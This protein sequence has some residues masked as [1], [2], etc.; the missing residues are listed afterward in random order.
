MSIKDDLSWNRLQGRRALGSE[1]FAEFNKRMLSAKDIADVLT[2]NNGFDDL[3]DKLKA[4]DK[5][6]DTEL[7]SAFEQYNQVGFQRG[8]ALACQEVLDEINS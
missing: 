5:L 1:L 6:F 4:F 3:K 8:Y 7:L 2:P